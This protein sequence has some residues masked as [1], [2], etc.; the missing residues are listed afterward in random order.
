MS[1]KRVVS[2]HVL[3]CRFSQAILT[4]ICTRFDSILDSSGECSIYMR[5]QFQ[6]LQP[7][8]TP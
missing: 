3:R 4:A 6:E 2:L 1:M 5:Y 8:G 7:K